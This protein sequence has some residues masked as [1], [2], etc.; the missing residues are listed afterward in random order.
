MSFFFLIQNS[1]LV[2]C[3]ITITTDYRNVKAGG[4]YGEGQI[5]LGM[6]SII[7]DPIHEKVKHKA[8]LKYNNSCYEMNGNNYE[9]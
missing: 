3:I 9:K 4:V 6:H 5:V 2:V 1:N 7:D 8:K